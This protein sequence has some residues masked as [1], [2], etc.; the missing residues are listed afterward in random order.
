MEPT[1]DPEDEE[2]PTKVSLK[3]QQAL[4]ARNKRKF[5]LEKQIKE[6]QKVQFKER[7]L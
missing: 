1:E 7:T 3:V 5:E 4:E 2:S 6:M